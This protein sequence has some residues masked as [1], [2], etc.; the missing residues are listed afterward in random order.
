MSEKRDYYAVLGVSKSA[1]QDEIKKAYRTLA[2]KYHPDNKE[3]GDAEKFK[4]ASEA[5]TV[6]SDEQKRK[7]YD[8][9]GQAAFDQT[10]GGQNPFNGSGFDGFNFNG[11]DFGDLNDILRSMFGGAFGGG[12]SRSYSSSSSRIEK[13]D[14]KL[15]RI[16]IKFMDAINGT[17]I[18][19]PIDYDE[20]CSECHGTGAKN[21]TEYTTCSTCKG[22]GR[23]LQTQR[24]IFGVIQQEVACP[25]CHGTGKRIKTACPNCS[26]QGYKHIRKDVEITIP[27][28]INNGQ[29]IRLQGKGERGYNGGE[30]GD[31]YVEVMVAAD[32]NFE[33]RDNDIYI[34]QPVDFVDAC[35]GATLIVPTVYGDVE[36]NLPS[37]TQP[38]QVLRIKGK[39]VKD[40][41]SS[42]YGD[43]YVK[44]DIKIPTYLNK[45]QKDALEEFKKAEDQDSFKD[46]FKRAWKK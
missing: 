16:R 37:G 24:S 15:M 44:I 26:G 12:G 19:L 35:L 10:S 40:V 36:L 25:D 46:K 22:K 6:L 27:A 14:D 3:T 1:T 30:N 18:T 45:K 41:R 13:G 29:Q 38:N 20:T 33:R 42:S 21:G 39:G 2:K 11:G 43:E 7:T 34:T 23:V 31:L 5:Y 32:K 4:E 8:Q 17:K 9:F 28:G